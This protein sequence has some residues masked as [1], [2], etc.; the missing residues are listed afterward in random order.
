LIAVDTNIL[1]YAHR[2]ESAWHAQ[3]DQILAEL[4]EGISQWAIPWPCLHEFLA[5]VTHPRIYNPPTPLDDAMEQIRCWLESPRLVLLSEGDGFFASW[6]EIVRRAKVRGGAVHDARIAALC[7]H[8]GVRKLLSADRDFSR[9]PRLRAENPLV[10]G[11]RSAGPR[12]E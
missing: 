4:A 7:L 11:P 12:K 3:A 9:F 5:V 10:K 2:A 6:Q 1:V 8:H